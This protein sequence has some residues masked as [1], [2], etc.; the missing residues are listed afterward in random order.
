VAH[1]LPAAHAGEDG[2]I[3]QAV[4]RVGVS[5][6]R[7][8]HAMVWAVADRHG[9]R[10]GAVRAAVDRD[11]H[12]CLPHPHAAP[13]RT[14]G[15]PPTP[16]LGQLDRQEADGIDPD[17]GR[18]EE[19]SPRIR[20]AD[21]PA[22]IDRGGPSLADDIERLVEGD[23][24]AVAARHVVEAAHGQDAERG[25]LVTDERRGRHA[26][27]A[28]AA[29]H[30][31]V[32]TGIGGMRGQAGEVIALGELAMADLEATLDE[33]GTQRIGG[34][35]RRVVRQAG[36]GPGLAAGDRVHEQQDRASRHSVPRW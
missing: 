8:A 22:G 31:H 15:A 13:E 6:Y 28:V 10:T 36:P 17:A 3:Q 30:N 14:G 11:P 21:D 2:D 34:Q 1:H 29:G 18:F 24:H 4:G 5:G 35:E 33:R 25:G 23:G 9:R 32:V 7:E 16:L 19:R 27:R 26:D 12:R 20:L